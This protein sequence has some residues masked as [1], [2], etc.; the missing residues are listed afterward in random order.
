[1]TDKEKKFGKVSIII[2]VYNTEPFLEKCLQSVLNQTYQNIEVIVVNDGS[3]DNSGNIIRKYAGS[4]S[5]IKVIE[6]KNAGVSAARNC[7]VEH[8][9]GDY[10]TF[11]D[12]DDYVGITYIEKC[13]NR[14]EMCDAEVVISGYTS[15][16][17]V[18]KKEKKVV[19][20]SYVRF[21]DES[22]AY[23]ICSTWGR[24]YRRDI[25]ENL[26]LRFP[27]GVRAEDV[28]LTYMVNAVCDKIAIESSGEYYYVQHGNSAM[29]SFKGLHHFSLPYDELEKT[30]AFVCRG[31]LKNSRDF[32]EIGILRLLTVF[33]FYFGRG[34]KREKL[35]EIRQY[36]ERIL[37]LY[38][39]DY[40]KNRYLSLF[41]G[42][43]NPYPLFQRAS[44]WIFVMMKKWG[45]LDWTMRF[46]AWMFR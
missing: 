21:A 24:L 44:V 30:I 3:T 1:M 29:H 23:R 8:A 43:R 4:D 27:V 32:F 46:N 20:D 34:A 40:D 37:S 2:P 38:F 25:W 14:A 17:F 12:G 26:E 10:I 13:V 45:L 42:F 19:P 41:P 6:Q 7:G 33:A 36:V 39:P 28:S 5:R 16:D 18:S 15:V 35:V 11:I 22:W 31:G 9:D